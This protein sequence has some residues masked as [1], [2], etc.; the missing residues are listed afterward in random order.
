[1]VGLNVLSELI[2]SQKLLKSISIF[3]EAPITQTIF[4][5]IVNNNYANL[6]YLQIGIQ[7]ISDNGFDVTPI[8]CNVLEPCLGLRKLV[9][10]GN[11]KED[12]MIEK[13]LLNVEKLPQRILTLCLKDICIESKDILTIIDRL[14]HIIKLTLTNI[15]TKDEFGITIE[16]LDKILKER[17]C[18]ELIIKGFNPLNS[19]NCGHIIQEMEIPIE[20][21]PTINF[22]TKYCYDLQQYISICS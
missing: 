9:L 4:S 18:M 10:I 17:K 5:N 11:V 21:L 6:S 13:Q 3:K 1:M 7:I 8:N 15:G 19:G 16:M 22:H 2:T 12:F 14:N 20:S